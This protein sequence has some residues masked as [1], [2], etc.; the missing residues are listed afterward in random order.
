MFT[1]EKMNGAHFSTY[2][3]QSCPPKT[4]RRGKSEY[5]PKIKLIVAQ[6]KFVLN[7]FS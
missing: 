4:V 1:A 5:A 7:I 2:K 3:P 6:T